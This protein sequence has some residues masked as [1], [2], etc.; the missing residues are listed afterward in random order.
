MGEV[1]DFIYLPPHPPSILY[2]GGEGVVYTLKTL[3]KVWL[4][5]VRG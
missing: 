1:I 4:A 2:I 5:V 3:K